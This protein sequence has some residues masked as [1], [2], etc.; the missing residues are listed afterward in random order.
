MAEKEIIYKDLSYKIMAAIFEVHNVLGPGFSE[1]IYEKALA[2]EFRRHDLTFTNQEAIKIMYGEKNI[3]LH[4]L[5]FVVDDKIVVEIKAQSDLM[6]IHLA[7]TKSYLKSGRFKL[8]ILA[9]FGKEKV[10]FKRILL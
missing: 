5:D 10:E 8:G 1:N 4:R 7:Q 9:N 2:E 3:G 6:P